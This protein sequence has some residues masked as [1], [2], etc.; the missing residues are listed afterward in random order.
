MNSTGQ[1]R[2]R[3]LLEVENGKEMDETPRSSKRPRDALEHANFSSAAG[4]EADSVSEI[5]SH[6]SGRLSPIKQLEARPT[7]Q[8]SHARLARAVTRGE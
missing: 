7:M 8:R 3:Y 6:H 2:K 1:A 5:E 4:S